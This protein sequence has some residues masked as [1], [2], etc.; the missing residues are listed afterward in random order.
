MTNQTTN[1]KL[2]DQVRD[3][4]RLK[5]YALSTEES[6][7]LW[8]KRFIFFHKTEGVFVHPKEMGRTEIEAFL[9]Y[10]AVKKNVAPSTQNQ[11]LSALLFLYREVL[12]ID[13]G[14]IKV[15]WAKRRERIP[16]VLT[17]EEALTILSKMNGTHH[18]MAQLLYG[19]GLRLMECVRLRVKDLDFGHQHI[20]V[21]DGKGYKDRATM[22]PGKLVPTLQAHLEIVKAIH[23]KDLLEGFGSV[24]LPDALERKYPNASREW[25]WQFIFPAN[26]HSKDPRSDVKRRHHLHESG[27]QKAVK[28]ATRLSGIEKRVTPHTFRH[29]FATHLL[30]AGYDIRT[31]QEL[32][33]HKNAKTTMIYTH[34][35]NKGPKAVRSPLDNT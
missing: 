34:V 17:K 22:L 30:E 18:L 5:H 33:G 27:L 24:Y 20:I 7:L 8:I 15:V 12:Q 2:L 32:L 28:N 35:L 1:K 19:S 16:T 14:Y 31:V 6:Y 25:V 29:S 13:P 11:A 10:L 21:R 9:T 23:K 3:T 26:N 4:L